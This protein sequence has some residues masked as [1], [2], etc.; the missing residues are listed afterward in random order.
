MKQSMR[1][2]VFCEDGPE[3]S[4]GVGGKGRRRE[5]RYLHVGLDQG[6]AGGVEGNGSRG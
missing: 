6:Y 1:T 5:Q 4:M 2:S 3:S